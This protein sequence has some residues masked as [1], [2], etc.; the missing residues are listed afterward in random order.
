M[1]SFERHHF[2]GRGWSFPP[3]FE[4]GTVVMSEDEQDIVESL[5]ILFG[6]R[7][8]E[9]FLQPK[10]GLDMS[11]LLFEPLSTT[12]RNLLEDRIRV[13]L[14]VFEARIVVHE[15]VVDDSRAFEGLLLIQLTY[16]VRSTNARFNLVYPYYLG[17]ANEVRA[18]VAAG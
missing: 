13:A 12:L 5:Q 7:P 10:F 11:E 6:T 4:A 16:S 3:R 14:L 15:L 1:S 18:Q 17:D 8:G 2:L 9:R